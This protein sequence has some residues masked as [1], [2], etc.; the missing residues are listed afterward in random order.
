MFF[1]EDS[2]SFQILLTTN[3]GVIPVTFGMGLDPNDC[4]SD[5]AA[6]I[7]F[8]CTESTVSVRHISESC[9][10]SPSLLGCRS[11]APGS[12]VRLSSGF[13]V[14]GVACAGSDPPSL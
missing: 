6:K 14:W 8:G 10:D 12:P 7:C 2:E 9:F 3:P 11:P 1:C 4:T 13:K 5:I